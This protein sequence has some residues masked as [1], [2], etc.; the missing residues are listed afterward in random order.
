PD[1]SPSPGAAAEDLRIR[2]GSAEQSNTSIVYGERWI[3][4][5]FR[6]LEEG[7]NLDRE[8]GEHLT[9][10]GFP[11][12]PDVVGAIE[13]RAGRAPT[14]TAAVL[15]CWVPNQSDA[16][17]FTLDALGRYFEAAMAATDDPRTLPLP[18][19]LVAAAR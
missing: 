16:W 14:A 2:L 1:A 12:T 17:E 11:H 18:G 4:K 5:L 10:V 3:L 9:R 6:R 13:Y 19:P 7:V 15:Q 8:L